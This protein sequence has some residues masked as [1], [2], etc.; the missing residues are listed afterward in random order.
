[1]K[2]RHGENKIINMVEIWILKVVFR[3]GIEVVNR[4]L[5]LVWSR[6]QAAN[7]KLRIAY[8]NEYFCLNFDVIFDHM[9]S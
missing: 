2:F 9:D 7:C 4:H 8:K 3:F 5:N 1:M 6:N